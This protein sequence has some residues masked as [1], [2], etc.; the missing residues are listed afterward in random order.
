MSEGMTKEQWT[1]I[2]SIVFQINIYRKEYPDVA[3]MISTIS[4]CCVM[5][6]ARMQL[7]TFKVLETLKVLSYCQ[8]TFAKNFLV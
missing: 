5:H 2:S 4:L 1:D 3:K 7:E 8:G 6:K